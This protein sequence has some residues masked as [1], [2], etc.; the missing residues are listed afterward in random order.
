MDVD[1][2][3]FREAAALIAS[4]PAERLEP[5]REFVDREGA[6]LAGLKIEDEEVLEVRRHH[7]ARPIGLLDRAEVVDGLV[8]GVFQT[9]AG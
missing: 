9:L 6:L 3:L 1:L 5:L 4:D 8:E 7:V 2:V